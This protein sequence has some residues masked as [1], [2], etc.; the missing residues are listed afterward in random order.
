MAAL[1]VSRLS[2]ADWSTAGLAPVA[3]IEAA[4]LRYGDG[5]ER[6]LRRLEPVPA[7]AIVS[8]Q[9]DASALA[10]LA[11]ATLGFVADDLVVSV[12]VDTVL[13]LGLTFSL[14]SAVGAAP[15]RGL[16]FGGTLD[17]K[18]LRDSGLARVGD[19]VAAATRLADSD[20]GLITRSL[21][22]AARSSAEQ[23]RQYDAELRQLR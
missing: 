23:A 5:A 16:L 11:T 4:G 14:P 2:L 10:L 9:C 3:L 7:V 20:A 15:A 13:A 19:P 17:A 22:V 21:R 12:D 1:S 8:G 18:A 6:F